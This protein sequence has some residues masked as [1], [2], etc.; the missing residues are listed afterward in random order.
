MTQYP[1]PPYYAA[2][3]Q[4][5][6]QQK[7][8]NGFGIA[9]LVIGIISLLVAWVPICGMAS[10]PLAA[11]GLILAVVGFIVSVSGGRSTVGMSVAGGIIC[12]I[13]II[14]PVVVTG[15][16]LALLG[17]AAEEAAKEAEKR[18]A[19]LNA[20]LAT[21]PAT[22]PAAVDPADLLQAYADDPSAADDE[23]K[24]QLVE[25]SGT[26]ADVGGDPSGQRYLT[27]APDGG[28]TRR[29]QCFFPPDEARPRFS[30]RKGESVRIRGRCEGLSGDFVLVKDCEVLQ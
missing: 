26:I 21:Q 27:F 23:Y 3:Q 4:P 13:A 8:V 20:R 19:E 22:A 25:L 1:Q 10:I 28:G 5:A 6:P 15:G 14:V 17:K 16:S 24:G 30:M 9:A 2:P 29:V 11:N 12:L 18:Q 7:G